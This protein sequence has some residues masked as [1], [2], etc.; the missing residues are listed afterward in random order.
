MTLAADEVV[1]ATEVVSPCSSFG[2]R[3]YKVSSK[4]RH[5]RS[6]LL[7]PVASNHSV[8]IG[9]ELIKVEP[10]QVPFHVGLLSLLLSFCR[11]LAII[12]L[13]AP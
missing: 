9:C 11:S 2:R 13:A 5:T 1:A 4:Y 8:L 10:F 12:R 3:G 6:N 7:P